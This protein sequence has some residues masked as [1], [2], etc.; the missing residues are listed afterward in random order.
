MPRNVSSEEKINAFRL[1][2]EGVG[3]REIQRITKLSRTYIRRLA[4]LINFQFAR[5]GIE[6]LSS[7]AMCTNC[8]SFFRR[9]YSKI[10]NTKHQF[11]DPI[12][13]KAFMH[14][15][16]HPSW[17]TGKTAASFSTW[18]KNQSEYK[19]WR[20]A[21]L[22]RDGGQCVVSGQTDDLDVH[23]I[24]PKAE[25]FN[26]EK[27]FD[28]ENGI[29]LSKEAHRRIHEL[30]R[31]GTDFNE[32]LAVLK[33]EYGRVNKDVASSKNTDELKEIYNNIKKD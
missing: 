27:A 3:Q 15:P 16:N 2:E 1:I 10:K 14:G 18:I 33:K 26:P 25:N 17:K 23:H 5:N 4:K 29:T 11:C 9:P 21:V 24:L 8:G 7:M 32:A 6:V 13:K 22:E 19:K 12:C 28:V 31:E 30:I 20:E